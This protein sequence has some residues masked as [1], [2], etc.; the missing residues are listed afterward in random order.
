V[1]V[2]LITR[3]APAGRRGCAEGEKSVL[4]EEE[5]TRA[6]AQD[7]SITCA[8][9]STACRIAQW[10]ADSAAVA[11]I[12]ALGIFGVAELGRERS[13]KLAHIR[14]LSSKATSLVRQL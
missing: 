13:L 14:A 1:E 5:F 6:V 12:G 10:G 3:P 7:Y 4:K 2:P 11:C 8:N 9:H